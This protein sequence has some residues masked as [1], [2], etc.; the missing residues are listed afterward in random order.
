MK[1]GEVIREIDVEFDED[2]IAPSIDR[3]RRVVG[4]L[5]SARTNSSHHRVGG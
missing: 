3:H 5:A 1:L 2:L 4:W